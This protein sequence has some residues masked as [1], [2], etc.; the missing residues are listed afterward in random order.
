VIVMHVVKIVEII[1]SSPEG[2]KEAAEAA[3]KEASKTVKNIKSIHLK[4]C[5]AKVKDDKIVE[6][7]AVVKVAFS[8]EHER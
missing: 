5:T 2:W 7:R 8:V 3:L 6:Y 1:G 4:K